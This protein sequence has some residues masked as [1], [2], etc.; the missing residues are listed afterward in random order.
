M[1]KKELH[2]H[3]KSHHDCDQHLEQVEAGGSNSV[4][5]AQRVIQSRE[6]KGF[7]LAACQPGASSGEEGG[8]KSWEVWE[9]LSCGQGDLD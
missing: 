6:E 1:K 5:A 4:A 9:K 2:L 8:F 7:K 3:D